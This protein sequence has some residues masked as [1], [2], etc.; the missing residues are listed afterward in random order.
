MNASTKIQRRK[1]KITW[2]QNGKTIFQHLW[3]TAK[4]DPKEGRLQQYRP[5]SDKN[6][7][8]HKLTQ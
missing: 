3:D 1:E 2:K 6:L 5:T 8:S 7:K 4:M